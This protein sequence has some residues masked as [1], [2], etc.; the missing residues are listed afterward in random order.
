MP[1]QRFDNTP[2]GVSRPAPPLPSGAPGHHY[3]TEHPIA[4]SRLLL[5]T[6]HDYSLAAALARYAEAQQSAY[7]PAYHNVNKP[8]RVANPE[9]PRAGY[10]HYISTHEY[11]PA[12]VLDR[13]LQ[14]AD[15]SA[16]GDDTDNFYMFPLE[17]TECHK[18][19]KMGKEEVESALN[20]LDKAHDRFSGNP[21]SMQ[22]TTYPEIGASRFENV[23]R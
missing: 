1:R 3:S 19:G 23:S 10:C 2:S 7:R 13:D 4:Q 8:E 6:Q 16:S 11:I 21:R 5:T 14:L 17:T 9:A 22:E 15:P 12:A 18:A 20:R